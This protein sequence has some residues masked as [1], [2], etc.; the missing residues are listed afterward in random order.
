MISTNWFLFLE[1]LFRQIKEI[2]RIWSS[3]SI[4]NL[5]VIGVKEWGIG[6]IHS[7]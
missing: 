3:V 5:K 6:K 1:R 2:G 7:L 4:K